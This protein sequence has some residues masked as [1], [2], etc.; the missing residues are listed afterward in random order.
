MIAEMA[1]TA[2]NRTSFDLI[3]FPFESFMLAV[4]ESIYPLMFPTMKPTTISIVPIA[5][6]VL[7][8]FVR[9]KSEKMQ[10]E[11]HLPAYSEQK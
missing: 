7:E 5:P 10:I 11:I 9:I 2:A 8:L 4:L 6:I 3:T 1:I